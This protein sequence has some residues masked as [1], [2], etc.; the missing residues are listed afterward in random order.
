ME[1][2]GTEASPDG[3]DSGGAYENVDLR[4][5]RITGIWTLSTFVNGKDT[6][7]KF[8]LVLK[9]SQPEIQRLRQY[10]CIPDI[11][12][13]YRIIAG[14]LAMRAAALLPDNTL[15]LA[16]VVNT[17]GR[18]VADRERLRQELGIKDE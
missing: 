5:Q 6:V 12:F 10:R 13:H 4:K 1:L 2:M 15:E 16:D 8:P 18:W 17:A 9:S 11:R 7:T 3:F 14:A